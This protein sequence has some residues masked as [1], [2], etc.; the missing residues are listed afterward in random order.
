MFEFSFLKFAL[1]IYSWIKQA[2]NQMSLLLCDQGEFDTSR[3]PLISKIII[4]L[5]IQW[6]FHESIKNLSSRAN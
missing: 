6:F 3:L 2:F 4:N 5:F 1:K